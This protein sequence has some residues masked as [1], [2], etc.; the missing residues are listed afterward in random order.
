MRIVTFICSITFILLFWGCSE[1]N[2]PLGKDASK[3][4]VLATTSIV[5]DLVKEIGDTAIVLESLMGAG[6]DPHLYKAS[7]GDLAKLRNADIIFYNGLHLEGKMT[8]IFEKLEHSKPTIPVA[9]SSFKGIRILSESMYDPHIWFS[10]S[11]WKQAAE[12][13]KNQ[14]IT[15]APKN[16]PYFEKNY[17]NYIQTLDS[18]D[19]WVKNAIDSI[20]KERRIL[21][22][23]HDAF[24][25]FGAEYG[26]EIHSLQGISTIAEFG[27][28]DV[29]SIVN[30]IDSKNI[31]AVFVESSVP[32]KSI[33][34]VISAVKT[35]NKTVKLG[36]TLHSDA[37]GER[38]SPTG[39]YIGMFK[40]NVQTIVEA[41][42]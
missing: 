11:L 21:V 35:R 38:N 41:L 13:V 30:I 1:K 32:P 26:I 18:F 27:I 31:P 3:L 28:N 24:A 7:S 14:L 9:V 20:P 5:A 33:Q 12:R 4:S 10:I 23:A 22:T 36:G 15:S 17:L 34:A 39:I 6:V 40:S 16:K 2:S 37:L 25:Y 8:D 29:I 42:R 19:M